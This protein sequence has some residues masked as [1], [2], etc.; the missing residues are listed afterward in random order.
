[1]LDSS[2]R[3]RSSGKFVLA[4]VATSS[5]SASTPAFSAVMLRAPPRMKRPAATVW[6]P[7]RRLTSTFRPFTSNSVTRRA[8]S[9]EALAVCASAAA[10]AGAVAGAAACRADA[11]AAKAS[12][13]RNEATASRELFLNLFIADKFRKITRTNAPRTRRS[14]VADACGARSRLH[15]PAVPLRVPAPIKS[16]G[17]TPDS[18]AASSLISARPTCGLPWM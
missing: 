10:R 6:L 8:A 9:L 7:S 1:M 17:V 14:S 3:I 12:A 18:F 16:S 2:A 15:L 5:I 13:R 11:G 4:S